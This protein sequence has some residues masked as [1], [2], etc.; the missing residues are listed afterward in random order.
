MNLLESIYKMKSLIWINQCNT[1]KDEIQKLN[2]VLNEKNNEIE[3]LR[4]L[5]GKPK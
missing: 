5:I 2:I 3:Y 1:L 4:S